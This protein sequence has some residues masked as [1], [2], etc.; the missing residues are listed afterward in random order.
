MMDVPTAQLLWKC[1][2]T[3]RIN[4]VLSPKPS[5]CLGK[6]EGSERR[7]A[8]WDD[9]SWRLAAFAESCLVGYTDT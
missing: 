8:R 4:L 9:L 1:L 5:N 6:T 2:C 7:A 3:N